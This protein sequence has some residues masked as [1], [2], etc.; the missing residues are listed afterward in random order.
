MF[1]FILFLDDNDGFID[2]DED[3]WM[4][5]LMDQAKSSDEESEESAMFDEK[6]S[7][8]EGDGQNKQS[9]DEINPFAC[10]FTQGIF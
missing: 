8:K 5:K 3:A 1:S 2:G 10:D 6:N 7:E 9:D 4:K